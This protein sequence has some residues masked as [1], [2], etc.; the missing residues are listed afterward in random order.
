M[1]LKEETV[2]IAPPFHVFYVY[3]MEKLIG[4]YGQHI[5]SSFQ[6]GGPR[7]M[8]YADRYNST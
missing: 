3:E 1:H 8:K 6:A 5:Q 4:C 7:E 2:A